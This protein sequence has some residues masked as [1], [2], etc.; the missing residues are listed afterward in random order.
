MKTNTIRGVLVEPMKHPRVIEIDRGLE[1]LQELVGGYIE[2]LT[3]DDEVTIIC[4][5][6]GKLM[7]LQPNRGVF[8]NGELV[9]IICGTFFVCATP[10][11]SEDFES[12]TDDQL[13]HYVA[14][15]MQP[16]MFMRVNGKIMA[17]K[18]QGGEF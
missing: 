5:E 14:V 13:L 1:S 7:G 18:M 12:L 2:A 6:E 10:W 3:I 8:H 4:N 9:D 11:D 15:Y 17:I 16:E